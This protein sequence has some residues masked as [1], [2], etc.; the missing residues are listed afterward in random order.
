MPPSFG[1]AT[2]AHLFPWSPTGREVAVLARLRPWEDSAGVVFAISAADGALRQVTPNGF[3]ASDLV[4]ANDGTP[5]VYG[6]ATTDRVSLSGEGAAVKPARADWWRFEAT[7]APRNLTMSLS[8]PPTELHLAWPD[9]FLYLADGALWSLDAGQGGVVR[10]TSQGLPTNSTIQWPAEPDAAFAAARDLV[11][12]G[13]DSG[14]TRWYHVRLIN[15]AV[16]SGLTLT[17]LTRPSATASFTTYAPKTGLAFFADSA[18][19]GTFVWAATD[20]GAPATRLL[21]FNEQLAGIAAGGQR[22]ITYRG[23]DGDTLRGD[24]LLPPDYQPGKRYPLIVWVY[25]GTVVQDTGDVYESKKS[26][27]WVLNFQPLAAHGYAILFPS[28][29]LK[30]ERE[31]SDPYFDLPKGVMTAVDRVVEVGIA[32]PNRLGVMGISFG[33]YSTYALVTHTTRF[34]AAVAMAGLSD[35]VTIY[36]QFDIRSRYLGAEQEQVNLQDW[37]ESAQGRMG[38]PP[39]DDLWHYMRNSPLFY[40]DRVETPVMIIQ[41]DMDFVPITQGEEFFSGL[42]RLGKRAKFVR[43]WGEGHLLNSPAN[44][45]HMWGQIFDWFDTYLRPAASAH[46]RDDE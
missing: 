3:D 41:G 2:V 22:L 38:G 45:R 1:R 19:T 7:A 32:D 4:W 11:L 14:R 34:K 37:A 15:G 27:D 6:R 35:L 12:Q 42:Y 43:Y 26:L 30:P 36:G 25:A 23:A 44:I 31:K 24:V 8:H 18:P 28:M 33:G 16:P 40:L 9:R 10:L 46:A 13:T 20:N 5:L 17:A 29:P 21:A 39:W